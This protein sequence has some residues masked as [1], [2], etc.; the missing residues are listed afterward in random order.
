MTELIA[1]HSNVPPAEAQVL[2]AGVGTGVQAT[3]LSSAGFQSVTGIDIWQGGLEHAQKRGFYR[4]LQQADLQKPLPAAACPEA[5]F[6]IVICVGVLTYIKPES[7]CLSELLRV[8]KRGGIICYTNRTDKLEAWHAVEQALVAS[9]AWELVART[10]RVPY[11]PHNQEFGRDTEIVI[12]T[13][14]KL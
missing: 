8:C 1:K 14:R 9:G 10:E 7:C 6:D 2:D 11:L 5:S 4:V 13:W 3:D 12:S